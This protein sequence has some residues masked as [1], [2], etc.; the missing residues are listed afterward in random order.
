MHSYFSRTSLILGSILAGLTSTSCSSDGDA[1]DD[2]S[3]EG[4]ASGQ[5]SASNAGSGNLTPGGSSSTA[6]APTPTG[7]TPGTPAA[8]PNTSPPMPE[9]SSTVPTMPPGSALTEDP[10]TDPVQPAEGPAVG[11]DDGSGEEAGENGSGGSTEMDSEEPSSSGGQA[12]GEELMPPDEGEEEEEEE[13]EP[14][15][16][17]TDE[18]P[19]FSFFT[20]SMDGLLSLAPDPVNGFGGDLGGLE[21]ADEICTTLARRANPTDSKTWVAFLSTAGYEGGEAVDAIDRIGSGPWYDYNQRLLAENVEGL[22]TG[23][24]RPNGDPQ[25]VEM[26]TDEY[27]EP[28]QP[29][30]AVDNH[31]MLTGSNSEGR[32]FSDEVGT[33]HDWTDNTVQDMSGNG[34]PV[35]H[36]WPRSATNGRDWIQE[37]TVNGCEPGIAIEQGGGAPRGDYTVG[38]AGGYGGFYC[39]AL[40]AVAP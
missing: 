19:W 28:I 34:V 10:M 36:A 25:L 6:V 14:A 13:P 3:N 31:D 9:V 22:L 24:G 23:D 2:A 1:A 32:L 20:T 37:H 29:N 39:F 35:G 12:S 5:P 26:F 15:G 8:A 33:C 18:M 38:A 27:G 16:D 40:G 17:G 11:Q 21:G 7:G 30:S 4:L